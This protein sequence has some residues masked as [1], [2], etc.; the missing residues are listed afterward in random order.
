MDPILGGAIVSGAAGLVSGGLQWLGGE[1]SNYEDRQF[2]R[3][4]FNRQLEA[5]GSSYQRAVA[6]M[7]MAGINPMLAY[8]R[9]GAST[10]SGQAVDNENTL[11]PAVSSAMAGKKLAA[12]LEMMRYTRNK[13]ASDISNVQSDTALKGTM[14]SYYEAMR[15]QAHM[16]TQLIGAEASSARVRAMIDQSGVGRF[17]EYLRRLTGSVS[18]LV[19]GI[20]GAVLGRYMGPRPGLPGNARYNTRGTDGMLRGGGGGAAF[21]RSIND[22]N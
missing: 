21:D 2:A 4:M 11:G 10:P 13:V 3:E 5:S 18:P 12:E 17:A 15:E 6:D 16:Q 19:G 14:Q 8:M 9:G 7:R 20:G 22:F 1:K